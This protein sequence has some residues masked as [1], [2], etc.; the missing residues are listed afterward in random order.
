[1]LTWLSEGPLR[2][3]TFPCIFTCREW[4]RVSLNR[5]KIPFM[6]TLPSSPNHLPKASCCNI[7]S[8]IRIPTCEFWGNKHSDHSTGP[9][10]LTFTLLKKAVFSQSRYWNDGLYFSWSLQI[11]TLN[12]Q[13]TKFQ[14]LLGFALRG[15][16]VSGVCPV[17]QPSG[18]QGALTL[19]LTRGRAR[20][21]RPQTQ[22]HISMRTR[23][24]PGYTWSFGTI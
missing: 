12:K 14:R 19:A 22:S 11:L 16:T 17:L 21:P 5:G 10:I 4:L 9:F 3:G 7:I 20:I 6:R 15:Y 2:R 24:G 23:V 18:E 8:G 13:N 1:M